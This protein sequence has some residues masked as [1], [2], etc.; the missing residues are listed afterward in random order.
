M[1][2]TQPAQPPAKF[3]IF[4]RK[5]QLS[6]KWMLFGAAIFLVCVPVFFQAPLVRS[7]PVFTL[8]MTI[9]WLATSLLLMRSRSTWVWGDL[10]LGFTL[11]WLTGS[12]YWGWL[13]GEPLLHLPIEAL[14]VP[15]ACWCLHRGWGKVGN[16]FYLGSLFGTAVTDGY[17]Y[18]TGLIPN[19][20]QLM[21]VDPT[22]AVSILQDAL[23]RVT[24]P[25]GI[26]W[27]VVLVML[28]LGVGLLPLQSKQLHKWV[29]SGAVLSTILVDSLFL[30]AACAA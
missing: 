10:L 16:W 8:L 25:W 21:T 3:Q 11:S 15:F 9:G 19:W 17:F 6:Q 13:R 30:I 1:T 2:T 14:G 27:A 28:L 23:E 12:I 26:S 4:L 20:R 7:W 22:F 5:V 24:T 29:F 18:I